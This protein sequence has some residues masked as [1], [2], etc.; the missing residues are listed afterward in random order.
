MV[1]RTFAG[2]EGGRAHI[3]FFYQ[4][5]G[6]KQLRVVETGIACALLVAEHKEGSSGTVQQV[7]CVNTPF[8]SAH[9]VQSLRFL[10]LNYMMTM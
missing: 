7:D 8:V 10:W 6:W 2:F 3:K 5:G 1:Q 9:L 4:S